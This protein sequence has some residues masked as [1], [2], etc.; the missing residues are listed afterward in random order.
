MKLRRLT[1]H[2][3]RSIGDLDLAVPDLL[4]LVGP[5]NA[6]K[7]NVLRALEFALTTSAKPQLGDFFNNGNGSSTE[8]WVEVTFNE[9][10]DQE[11]TTF[12][13]YLSSDNSL[14][15]RKTAQLGEDGTIATSYQG[16]VEEAEEWWLQGS[17]YDR[18]S[19]R[20]KIKQ[21]AES[22]QA[23]QPLAEKPGKITKPDL[24]AFQQEYINTH[25]QDLKLKRKLENGPFMGLKNVAGGL[26]PEYYLVPAIRELSDEIKIKSTTLLG[27]LLQ[28]AVDEMADRNQ[29]LQEAVNT[30]EKA[31]A[32]LNE[33]SDDKSEMVYGLAELERAL[34]SE[35]REN[36]DVRVLLEVIAPDIQKVL[37]LGTRLQVDDGLK[38]LAEDKGHG[39]QRAL[40]F[41]L[42][43]IWADVLRKDSGKVGEGRKSREASLSAVWA[44]EEPELFLHPHA[45]RKLYCSLR[46][47]SRTPDNQVILCTHSTHFVD[48]NDYRSI[49]VIEKHVGKKGTAARQCQTDLFA[50]ND[51]LSQKNRF[52]MAYWINPDRAEVFFA[53]KVVL[54]EGETERACL[55]Y[56]AEKLKCDTTGIT[57]V[58]CGGKH[59]LLLYIHIL[60]AFGI[61][62]CVV[63]DEDPLPGCKPDSMNDDRWKSEQRT[64]QLNK[65][66]EKSVD[67]KY[68]H[69]EM[70]SPDFE[71]VAGIPRRLAEKKGKAVAALEYFEGK[72]DADLPVGLVAIVRS[73]FRPWPSRRT[74]AGEIFID[75]E[76]D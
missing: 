6:G 11:K 58:D 64:Y 23:L 53:K 2:D 32:K 45:Q 17:A 29:D 9:L 34:T 60:N 10:T 13:K 36:W 43:R 18:L 3:Y 27:R 1:I 20:E 14:C 4:V 5:N 51:A 46:N 62:Y 41:A 42:I 76:M 30:L 55:P 73:A 52:H 74:A 26:L 70:M 25:R 66:I 7:S 47:I 71:G 31:I 68:G 48:M 63:H 49:A 67:E 75:H 8:L 16:Y 40:I 21:E 44:I 39:L 57:I 15:I 69:R 56:L 22:V 38:T 54:V 72:T 35:L 28:R 19:S 59:N 37:E 61:P 50:G 33:R 24:E 12:R 65:E